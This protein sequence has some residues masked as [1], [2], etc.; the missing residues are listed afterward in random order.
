MKTQAAKLEAY[1]DWSGLKINLSKAALTGVKHGNKAIL[2]EIREGVMIKGAD[3]RRDRLTILGPNEPYKYVGVLLTMAGNWKEEKYS[4]KKAI[5]DRVA[6]LL[7][8]PLTPNQKEYSLLTLGN[9]GEIQI[10][11][12][13]SA[14]GD[15]HKGKT[16]P[17][18]YK[19]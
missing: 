2:R 14:P 10:W 8:V 13:W 3:V 6:A 12:I 7:K 11:N 1:S 16:H 18:T 15:L 5:K 9:T 19:G 4:T 17:I